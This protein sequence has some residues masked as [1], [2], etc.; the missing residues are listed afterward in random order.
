MTLV[1]LYTMCLDFQPMT[2]EGKFNTMDL[3]Q[4]LQRTLRR[5]AIATTQLSTGHFPRNLSPHPSEGN[6]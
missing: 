6:N 2:H 5:R 4:S 3:S 1:P